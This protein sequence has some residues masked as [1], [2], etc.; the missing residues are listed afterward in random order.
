MA[1]LFDELEP[2]ANDA[3]QRTRIE[4]IELSQAISL[5]RIAYALELVAFAF[6]GDEKNTGLLRL[7]CD[8]ANRGPH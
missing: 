4:R 8:M 3:V 6:H 1:N 5:R 2:G 7:A